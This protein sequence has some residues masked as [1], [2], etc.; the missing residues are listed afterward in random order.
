[1]AM[2]ARIYRY[3]MTTTSGGNLSILDDDGNIWIT[4][5]AVDKGSITAEDIICVKHDGQIVGKHPP[6][7]EFPFHKEVYKRC[8]HIKSVVHAH[9]VALVAFSMI[10]EVPNTRI[11]HQSY[12]VCG[13]VGFAPYALPGSAELGHSIA[14]VFAQGCK[15]V[16]MENH[17]VVVGGDNLQDAFQRFETLE[18]A[19]KTIIKAR[20]L[21]DVHYLSDEEIQLPKKN[22]EPLPES[23][24]GEASC[25]EKEVRQKLR[26]FV[27]RGYQQRLVISTEGSFS[28][29]V[30]DDSFL[31]TPYQVDRSDVEIEDLV[32]VREGRAERGR[33]PSRAARNH[34]AIYQ[35]HP[36]VNAIINAYT[37][38]A[39][40][41]SAAHLPVD[42]R[43]IPESYVFLRAPGYIEYGTQLG[44]AKQVAEK[45]SPTV[46]ACILE[47]DGMLVTGG[48]M[49][50]AFD[51]LEVL[52]ST[53]EA[54]INSKALGE[55]RVMNDD[56]IKE[57]EDAFF[58]R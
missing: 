58:K 28:A 35:A 53:A 21:G 11:F 4:P 20:Q 22:F 13:E 46:L 19:A 7:S 17:G 54:I 12:S 51:K 8:P 10:G 9:P 27:R 42:T 55:M 30:D 36:H 40:A 48:T 31:I 39:S 24:H 26:D 34:R 49:L 3:R 57:L 18:F 50:Q 6:S 14:D 1:M 33:I 43:T 38:N 47:N 16:I 45:F 2:M 32:L 56:V 23:D 15:S 41:F 52:E 37:V 5:A 25:L 44:D 29:R